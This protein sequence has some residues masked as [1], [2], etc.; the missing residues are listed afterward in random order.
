[1]VVDSCCGV[2]DISDVMY[3]KGS[4]R[5]WRLIV[6]SIGNIGVNIKEVGV[7]CAADSWRDTRSLAS[8]VYWGGGSVRPI[9]RGFVDC[10]SKMVLGVA[11]GGADAGVRGDGHTMRHTTEHCV[12][13][14]NPVVA[15][16]RVVR[17]N[18][19]IS[20]SNSREFML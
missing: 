16:C 1:M 11:K 17:G 12:V 10:S 8:S 18:G 19:E 3:G 7:R 4:R 15:L 9:R 5:A 14:N 6:R 2:I 13:G 20:T